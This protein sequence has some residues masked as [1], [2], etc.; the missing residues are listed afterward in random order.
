MTRTMRVRL[1]MVGKGATRLNSNIKLT[2]KKFT[3]VVAGKILKSFC[4]RFFDTLMTLL[5]NAPGVLV[6]DEIQQY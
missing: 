5:A 6:A 3:S 4:T 2:K 1:G